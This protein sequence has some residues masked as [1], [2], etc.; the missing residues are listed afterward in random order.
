M[1]EINGY[2][3]FSELKTTNSGFSKWGF[4][5]RNGSRFFIKELIDPIANSSR[6]AA[7]CCTT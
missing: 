1:K 7:S 6:T 4:A 5:Q 3:L 2:I